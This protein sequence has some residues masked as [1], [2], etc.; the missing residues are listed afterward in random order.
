MYSNNQE[1]ATNLRESERRVQR[2]DW[3]E[4]SDV[5]IIEFFKCLIKNG[6]LTSFF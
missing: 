1:E 3:E 6:L 4:E 5:I 2:E